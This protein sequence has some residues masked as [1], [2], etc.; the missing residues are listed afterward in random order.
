MKPKI[1]D[2]AGKSGPF[3]SW[4]QFITYVRNGGTEAILKRLDDFKL[5]ENAKLVF[6][7]GD[8]QSY[9]M[10]NGSQYMAEDDDNYVSTY[11]MVI[12]DRVKQFVLW[13]LDKGYYTDPTIALVTM[14]YGE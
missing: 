3:Y 14:T 5:S 2:T 7:F 4:E 12:E 8:H 10:V 11:R 1:I 9:F 6:E 13:L